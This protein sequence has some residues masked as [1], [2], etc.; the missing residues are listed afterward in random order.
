MFNEKYLKTEVKSYDGKINVNFHEN[1][2][3]K[4]GLH[5]LFLSVIF[6]YSV[7]KMGKNYYFIWVKK[8]HKYFWKSVSML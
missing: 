8:I 4:E 3:P 6:I 1:R 5:G 2:I 7:V